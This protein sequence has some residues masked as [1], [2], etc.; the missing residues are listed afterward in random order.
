MPNSGTVMLEAGRTAKVSPEDGEDNVNGRK[1][2]SGL[3]LNIPL[4]LSVE[5]PSDLHS[6]NSTSA[7]SDSGTEFPQGIIQWDQRRRSSI[8]SNNSK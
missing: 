3:R 6:P 2:G 7:V 8:V 4:T 5:N 1:P